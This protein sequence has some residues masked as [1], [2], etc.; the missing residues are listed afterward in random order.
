V[1]F[2]GNDTLVLIAC[3]SGVPL[4]CDTI[5]YIINVDESNDVNFIKENLV[6][7][8]VNPNPFDDEIVIQYYLYKDATIEVSLTDIQGK[9]VISSSI[10]SKT[11]LNYGKVKGDGVAKGTYVLSLKVGNEIYSKKIVK[12]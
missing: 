12:E 8:G 6:V 11:G 10:L 7:F 5:I 1:G 9:K 4:R 3:K 2:R